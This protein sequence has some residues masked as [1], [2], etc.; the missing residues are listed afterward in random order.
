MRACWLLPL[1]LL[2]Y[3]SSYAGGPEFVAGTS[4]FDPT[5]KGAPLTW[6]QPFISYF[7]DQGDLSPT[8]LGPNADAFVANAFGMWNAVS[9]SAIMMLQSGHLAEDVSSANFTLINGVITGPVDITPNASSTAV[10]VVYD[11]DG[12]VTDALLGAGASNSAYCSSNSTLGGVDSFDVSGH[13]SHAL[14]ILN[15]NCAQTSTQLPDLQYHL[16]RVIGRV[17]GLDW[18]Q[19][20]LNVITRNP[21]SFAADYAGFPVMHEIEPVSCIPVAICYSNHGTVN[22]A[23]PKMDDQ[24]ALSGLYPVTAQNV[25]NF[26]GKQIFAQNTARVSGSVF[27][28][29]ASGVSAQPM[30]GVN[31]VARWIDPATRLPS[32]SIVATSVSGFLFRGNAGNIVSGYAD[33]TGQNFD[34]FGSDDTAL[35]GFFDLAGLPIPNGAT[36]AQ[37]QLTVEPLDPLWSTNVGP[38]GSAGQVQPSGSAQPILLTVAPGGNVKQD[39]L[40]QGGAVQKPQWYGATTYAAPVPVP[41]SG[42]WAGALGQYGATDYFQFPVR[43]NRTL[44]VIVNALD[45]TG[46]PTEGKAMPVAGLWDIADPGLTP[47]PANTPSAFNTSYFAETRLDAQVFQTT[48]L[49]LGIADY[50]GDGRPDYKYNARI[51]Y[52]DNVTPTRAS[53]AGGTP[54]TISGFGLQSDTL[55]QTAGLNVPLLASSASRLL[56]NSPPLVDGVYDF[57]LSDA[58]TGGSSNMSGVLTV[59][60]GPSDQIKIVSGANQTAAVGGQAPAPLVVMALA[61][62]GVTTVPGASV[63]FTST[64]AGFSACGGGT[65]CTVLTDQSGM[66]STFMTPLSA[67]VGTVIAKLAPATYPL[68]QQVSTALTATSSQLDLALFNPSVW[69][70]QGASLSFPIGARVLSNGAPV[71][72]ST[73]NYRLVQGNGILTAATSQTDAAGNASVNLQVSSF[74]APVQVSICVA[75]ANNVC[76]IFTASAVPTPFFQVQPVAGT[77]QVVPSGQ[78]F[79]PAVVRVVDS[80]LPANPVLGASVL[81]RSYVGRIGQNQ[82]I[83]WVGEAGISWPGTPVI[84]SSAQTTV[85]SDVNGLVTYP[86]SNQGYS[87]NVIVAGTATAGNSSVQF[88]AEQVG[89]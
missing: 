87:G 39:I 6:P 2:L 33:A 22:P 75:P 37:Y 64:S 15:G 74:S 63:Q 57:L 82:T 68:P 43:T 9:T 66:A 51:L 72:G 77:L 20:N 8:M 61:Q 45:E 76:Q 40:M 58:N 32:R 79:Q 17:L 44:S 30:Q 5:V 62:D 86:I 26:P 50:R 60:A 56:V 35:E 24:A 88:K 52:G 38:Y 85:Q 7:T 48:T 70:A 54:L 41:G 67:G 84:L 14:I 83:I 12:S 69:I 55:V 71:S 13:F 28:T 18:S 4:F 78:S 10:G 16:V 23:Q 53:V 65:N 1:L 42:E 25:G 49:R 89:P 34:R 3:A 80:S 73:L 36:S 19:A 47:A 21:P 31:V 27:F 59:G 81:F 29:D 11:E 46:K